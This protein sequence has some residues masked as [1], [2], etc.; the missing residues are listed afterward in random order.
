[1]S[2][3]QKNEKMKRAFILSGLTL[4][5]FISYGQYPNNEDGQYEDMLTPEYYNTPIG[6]SFRLEVNKFVHFARQQPFQH[7]FKDSLGQIPTYTTGRS[8]GEGLGPGGTGS[9]HP[10]FDYY[11]GSSTQVNMYAA[12]NGIVTISRDVERYRHYLSIT[13]D[14]KDSLNNT[15]GKMVTFYAHIDLD[16]DSIDNINLDGQ[17]VH[18]GDLVSKHLYSGTMGGPHLHFE[19]RYYRPT[20][21]GIEDFYGGNVGGNTTP[22]SGSWSYGFW[23]P[24]FGYGFAHPDNHLDYS[25]LDVISNDFELDISVYPIPTKDFV[26]ID[27]KQQE[28]QELCYYV[29]NF[30]GQIITKKDVLCSDFIKIDLSAFNPGIYFLKLADKVNGDQAVIRMIKE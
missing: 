10:A 14:I 23:N 15:I 29:Y 11:V 21:A 27:L 20:D 30:K 26:T 17:Y 28:F 25:P 1:L 24:G 22:S 5:M 16:L 2:Y 12:H 18:K 4:L 6:G 19:I 7:P 8:F 13:T 9:H 3:R